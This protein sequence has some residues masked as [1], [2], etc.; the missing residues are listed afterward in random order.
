M[1]AVVKAGSGWGG[2]K[3]ISRISTSDTFTTWNCT[4]EVVG[5]LSVKGSDFNEKSKTKALDADEVIR[6]KELS[7]RRRMK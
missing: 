5:C 2:V 7:G 6:P 3:G 1:T 4:F